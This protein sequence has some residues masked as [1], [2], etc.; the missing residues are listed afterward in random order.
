[1][2]WTAGLLVFSISAA[3]GMASPQALASCG[4][5]QKS[6]TAKSVKQASQ[7]R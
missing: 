4:V 2:K 1:M 6:A 3:M 7:P 5:I